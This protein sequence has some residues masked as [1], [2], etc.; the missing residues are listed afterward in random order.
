[1]KIKS[2]LYLQE[3][4]ML[5]HGLNL[6][7]KEIAQILI[8]KKKMAKIAS[9]LVP[10]ERANIW[11]T[12]AVECDLMMQYASALSELRD[13]IMQSEGVDADMKPITFEEIC[14]KQNN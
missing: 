10:W 9:L 3:L 5:L 11:M 4:N 13:K 1:M 8:R 2:E 14:K 6:Q 7:I 12:L